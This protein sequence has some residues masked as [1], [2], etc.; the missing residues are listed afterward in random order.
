MCMWLLGPRSHLKRH[1]LNIHHILPSSYLF[2]MLLDKIPWNAASICAMNNNSKKAIKKVYSVKI[3][4]Q[5]SL[6]RP[7]SATP[8]T[9][10]SL[11]LLQKWAHY[12]QKEGS[13]G[14]FIRFHTPAISH[15]ILTLLTFMCWFVCVCVCV[16][17]FM[18]H[19]ASSQRKCLFDQRQPQWRINVPS[20]ADF[21]HDKETHPGVK[22]IGWFLFFG[23]NDYFC[24]C[25]LQHTLYL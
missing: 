15:C 13:F 1:I 11:Q 12:S 5:V 24:V 20:Y 9:L 8:R 2:Q 23:S 7:L 6:P 21:Q 25:L 14:S 10:C 16:C 19:I 3:Y 4:K 18:C 17:A 22:H